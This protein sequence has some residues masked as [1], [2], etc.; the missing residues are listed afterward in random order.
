MKRLKLISALLIVLILAGC[1]NELPGISE[2]S[3]SILDSKTVFL[4]GYNFEGTNPLLVKND[5]NKEIFSLI[6]DGLFTLDSSYKPVAKLAEKITM[7]TNDG[8]NYRV[9]LK[10]NVSFHDGTQM[11]SA[12]VVAT[13]N[14]LLNNSTAYDYNVKKISKVSPN[15][16]MGVNITLSDTT[17][18]LA[19]LLTFPIVNSK[20]ILKE[21]S[22]NGT[23]M[24]KV[25]SYV[26]RKYIDLVLNENYY[27]E[28][29]SE[30]EKIQIQLMPDKE[31]ANYA[32]SSGMSD[33]FSQDIFTDVASLN[34]K[35]GSA[36]TEYVS[37]NYGFL[38]LNNAH[39]L[40]SDKEVR[41]AVNIAVNRE[42]IVTDVLFSHAVPV[43]T[44]ILTSSSFAN[45]K[46]AAEYNVEEAKNILL[47]AGFKPDA[48][49]GILY[50]ESEE[51]DIPFTFDI[52]V[53]NDN[54]FRIQVANNISE[55]LKY[56]GIGCNVKIVS[57][58]EYQQSYIS[59]SY[60]AFIGSVPM[61]PDFDLSMFMGEYN[62]SNYYSEQAKE[63]L[64]KTGLTDDLNLKREFYDKLQNIFAEDVPHIS[65]Y[66]TKESIQS[67]S[68]IKSGLNPTGF[69]IFNNIEK[70]SF[71]E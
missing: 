13:F 50:K 26:Q 5:T 22:F 48:N 67:S 11:T 38:L 70:W 52:L 59:K 66:Y 12:D 62:I 14:Y 28:K 2:N 65:L 60:D 71:V 42:K 36:A 30:I 53:N 64:L 39:P 23:G 40:F 19:A 24:F 61:S 63:I 54:N 1:G 31:T 18:N 29:N 32:Y 47:K 6:Y 16:S 3:K 68:K 55:S 58:E 4:I 20:D 45:N 33:I 21:F 17:V 27:D 43:C 51:G 41:K 15:G 49:T 25:G 8:L 34:P 35:T 10:N 57:F 69:N 37:L 7:T 46:I 44:P 9:D 56:A